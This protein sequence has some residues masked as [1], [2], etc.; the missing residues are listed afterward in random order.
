MKKIIIILL[1]I[2]N[3]MVLSSCTLTEILEQN[4]FED[5]LG[6]NPIKS[7]INEISSD[8]TQVEDNIT[9]IE[10][11]TESEMI[12]AAEKSE[13]NEDETFQNMITPAGTRVELTEDKS[14]VKGI[15]LEKIGDFTP[16]KK[17]LFSNGDLSGGLYPISDFICTANENDVFTMC[18]SKGN[19]I[20]N[21]GITNIYEPY[22]GYVILFQEGELISQSQLMTVN[23]DIVIPFAEIDINFLNERFL[24]IIVPEAITENAAEAILK[25]SDS[26]ISWGVQ[27]GDILFKGYKKVFDL[28]TGEYVN[29]IEYYSNDSD[30]YACGDTLYVTDD[31]EYKMILDSN[32]NIL[33]EGFK[34]CD[35]IGEM[36]SITYD[37]K[38]HTIYDSNMNK[39]FDCPVGINPYEIENAKFLLRYLSYDEENNL[40]YGVI[41][42]SGNVLF[43][44]K[45]N[46]IDEY[47]DGLFVVTI[48]KENSLRGLCDM[49]GSVIVPCEYEYIEY[50]NGYYKGKKQDVAGYVLLD[51]EGNIIV[52]T[53]NIEGL[54][55]YKESKGLY[56]V[57]TLNTGEYSMEFEKKP[58]YLYHAFGLLT[59]YDKISCGYALFEYVNGTQLT[60][61][62]YEEFRYHNGCIYALRDDV[63]TIYQINYQY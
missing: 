32:G 15:T 10:V 56:Y 22:D 49:N 26:W 19:E 8:D 38:S 63:Y 48:D 55:S 3:G 21:C 5:I 59:A 58:S 61:Y 62:V 6:E 41:D 42:S 30:I 16:S 44:P 23:G 50:E 28:K 35:I 46:S 47:N 36:Y 13:S 43:E 37:N 2:L 51:C 54:F 17:I 39:L 57:L 12:T 33:A 60:E 1:S 34:W 25:I 7:F 45:F 20:D 4:S 29:N 14:A 11:E 31:H 24:E 18:D 9:D 40:L 53:N 52:E 27:E